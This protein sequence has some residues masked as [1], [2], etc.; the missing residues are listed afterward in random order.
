M[1][2]PSGKDDP[3]LGIE[4]EPLLDS[5]SSVDLDGTTSARQS[6][7]TVITR[8]WRRL[9]FRISV[10]VGLS[11]LALFLLLTRPQ[12]WHPSGPTC[13]IGSMPKD[14]PPYG[15]EDCFDNINWTTIDLPDSQT[16]GLLH[17][18]SFIQLPLNTTKELSFLSQGNMTHG[19]FRVSQNG[20]SDSNVAVG[21][22]A[23]YRDPK[24]LTKARVCRLHPAEDK[25]GLGIFAP[26]VPPSEDGYRLKLNVD[27]V[28]PGTD[29]NGDPLAL[30]YVRMYMRAYDHWLAGLVDAIYIDPD[31]IPKIPETSSPAGI[32]TA[33]ASAS[34]GLPSPPRM[35]G[36]PRPG[37][38]PYR[39]VFPHNA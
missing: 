32:P 2:P 13:F 18:H 15:P 6:P 33:S 12:E 9:F 4:L 10:C 11:L 14:V 36:V 25:W 38:P 35:S 22:Q 27:V 17:A 7:S 21:I 24:E 39:C 20:A 19:A 16:T 30:E 34:S 29:D 1:A 28:L 5:E 26:D 8:S 37:A 23:Y 31:S 3:E